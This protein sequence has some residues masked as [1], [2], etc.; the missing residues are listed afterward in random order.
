MKA[1][2]EGLAHKLGMAHELHA[3]VRTMKA[4][5][6]SNLQQYE[7]AVKAMNTYT[8]NIRKGM[9]V[10]LQS[11]PISAIQNAGPGNT[12]VAIVFGSGQGLA[13]QFNDIICRDTAQFLSTL[14]GDKEVWTV[15]PFLPSRLQDLGLAPAWQ[16]EVPHAIESITFLIQQ[17][18][19][20]V[21]KVM[22]A[23][24]GTTF[25]LFSNQ[26]VEGTAYHPV[27][28]RFL[29][30]DRTWLENIK[31]ENWP[32][33]QRPEAL[34]DPLSTMRSLIR[35]YLFVT[36]YRASAESLASEN[37]SRLAAME[38]ADKNIDEILNS[39]TQEY[40][41]LRQN[42][43]DEEMFDVIAGAQS[44]PDRKKKSPPG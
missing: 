25:Y 43:I 2:L 10:C 21:E 17:I 37:I 28:T 7:H 31:S 22:E 27:H 16:F 18:L 26:P 15:G 33:R 38:R 1:T 41:Q 8:Q 19:T 29:P 32:T 44:L 20:Q 36:I 6:A 4:L 5:S 42:S 39:L 23:N 30:L 13:G 3:V 40:H 12:N 11:L 14:P 24:P 34:P 9:M 35:E